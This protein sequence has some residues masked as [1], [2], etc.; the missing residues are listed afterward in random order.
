MSIKEGSKRASVKSLKGERSGPYVVP[1]TAIRDFI[2]GLRVGNV[3]ITA[4]RFQI[5]ADATHRE[6]D[7]KVDRLD[8]SR[9]Q[10]LRNVASES[11]NKHYRRIMR[12]IIAGVGQGPRGID[13]AHLT[14]SYAVELAFRWTS[15]YFS[16]LRQY[17]D[18][19]RARLSAEL[20]AELAAVD[21]ESA[22]E[23]DAVCNG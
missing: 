20:M 21:S 17:R 13:A 19:L 7:S 12:A 9:V 11:T 1:E 2:G 18:K 22:I 8:Q 10:L 14:A 23:T 15:D 3:E 5:V 6:I 16:A 4:A